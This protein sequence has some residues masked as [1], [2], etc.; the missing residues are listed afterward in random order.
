MSHDAP[1]LLLVDPGIARKRP[2]L[3]SFLAQPVRL[4]ALIDSHDDWVAGVLP[5]ENIIRARLPELETV[6]AAVEA[7]RRG[8]GITFDGV[9]TCHEPAVVAAAYLA[10]AYGLPGPSVLAAKRSSN[11]KIAMRE[12]LRDSGLPMPAFQVIDDLDDLPAAV[13]QV[14]LPCVFK[15]A[16]GAD[17]VSVRKIACAADVA[18]AQAVGREF[19]A[20]RRSEQLP[21]YNPRWLVEAYLNGPVI[22]VDGLVKHGAA[23]VIGMTETELGPEPWFNIEVNWMPPR[24]DSEACE[25]CRKFVTTVLAALGFDTCGFH[26]EIRLTDSGPRLIEIAARIPGGKMPEGYRQS[27][28][29]DLA[30]IMTCLWLGQPVPIT[31]EFRRYVFQKGVFPRRDGVLSHLSGVAEAA[32]LPGVFDFSVI[33]ARGEPAITYPRASKPIYYYAVEAEDMERLVALSK[34]VETTVDWEIS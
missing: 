5:G 19:E 23:H 9:G 27:L 29:I 31:P 13:A 22:S 17:S 28:G 8:R 25:S 14:G 4:F 26:A 2:L 1:T 30:K 34:Q 20:R 33:T 12:A 3:E 18:E 10:E 15:P 7:F 11:D 24:L 6:F 16:S 21:A 32:D